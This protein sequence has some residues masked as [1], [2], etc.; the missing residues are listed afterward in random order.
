MNNN[1]SSKSIAELEY[2]AKDAREAAIAMRGLDSVAECKYLDQVNDACSE[3]FKR[4]N[5]VKR[6]AQLNMRFGR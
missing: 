6:T 5:P 3:L 4:R 1:Y 2:I